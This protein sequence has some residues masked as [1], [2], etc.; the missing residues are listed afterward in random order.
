[1]N[2]NR[3]IAPPI[4]TLHC[5]N[6]PENRYQTPSHRGYYQILSEILRNQNLAVR[7]DTGKQYRECVSKDFQLAD[8]SL[9][10]SMRTMERYLD[11]DIN[12]LLL[13]SQ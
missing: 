8:V 6:R 10:R 9:R 2:F 13:F 5:A 11:L 4:N 1:V 12:I 3:I 7:E